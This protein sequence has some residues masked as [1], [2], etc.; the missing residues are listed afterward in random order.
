VSD[1]TDPPEH[2]PGVTLV[3]LLAYLGDLLSSYQDQ[4]AAESSARRRWRAV[5]VGAAAAAIWC[6]RRRR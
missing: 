2:D 1:W 6:C 5:A 4:V 3:E